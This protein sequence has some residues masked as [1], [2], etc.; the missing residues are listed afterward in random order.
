MIRLKPDGK[1]C[2]LFNRI[3]RTH[4]LIFGVIFL[5]LLSITLLITVII[6]TQN[7]DNTHTNKDEYCLTEGCLSAATY[8]LNSLDNTA[9]SNLCTDFYTYACGGWQKTHLIQAFDVERTIL[10]DIIDQRD[11]EIERLLNAPISRINPESWEYK[12][13]VCFRRDFLL[14]MNSC[15]LIDLLF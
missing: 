7:H 9:S 12:L 2:T 13:K 4:L 3:T 8:Q 11:M 5:G 1:V 10:G 14:K 6:Q 15:C